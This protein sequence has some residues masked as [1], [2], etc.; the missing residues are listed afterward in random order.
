MVSSF[1]GEILRTT[2]VKTFP[3]YFTWSDLGVKNLYYPSNYPKMALLSV[4][5]SLNLFPAQ[6]TPAITNSTVYQFS[7]DL[8]NARG[9]H[10]IG[11]GV[12]WT[13]QM[14]NYTA[15]TNAPGSFSF[16]GA[17]PGLR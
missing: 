11:Y 2:N 5:G 1:A 17:N 16:T 4:T 9:A 7:E 13:H 3:D 14:M 6:A 8:T 12:N 15:S 10:Q